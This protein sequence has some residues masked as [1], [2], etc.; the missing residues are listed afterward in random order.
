MDG[1][2][3][4]VPTMAQT[5][6]EVTET[7]H[8]SSHEIALESQGAYQYYIDI[9]HVSCHHDTKDLE[10]QMTHSTSSQDVRALESQG[11]HYSR[12][13]TPNSTGCTTTFNMF[14]ALESQEMSYTSFDDLSAL[15]SQGREDTHSNKLTTLESQGAG[16]T[17]S[18]KFDALESQETSYTLFDDLSALES[19]G[20]EEICSDKLTTLE[21]Q[22]GGCAP[23][24]KFDALESQE[25]SCTS[26]DDLSALESQGREETCSN[27]L[28]TLESQGGGCTPPAKFD[29]LESQE[30][31]TM[32][33]SAAS[34]EVLSAGAIC[35]SSA[36]ESQKDDS[37]SQAALFETPFTNGP[38]LYGGTTSTLLSQKSNVTCRSDGEGSR[39]DQGVVFKD[40][41][42][43]S[44][45][46]IGFL[47]STKVITLGSMAHEVEQWKP[48]FTD[49]SKTVLVYKHQPTRTPPI[50]KPFYAIME[51]ENNYLVQFE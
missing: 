6:T 4:Q 47:P 38:R 18:A 41:S 44:S 46:I 8:T 51:A 16:C 42:L 1:E 33:S 26:F 23:P 9:V 7:D 30:M 43:Q 5:Q 21:S 40:S 39:N 10:I 11:R 13:R 29:A 31:N 12:A 49:P 24:A 50:I 48:V 3:L 2:M 14:N 20:K 25:T 28:T 36:L 27:K 19:Q 35:E 22:G 37:P 32:I 15:E 34:K 17:P 45:C